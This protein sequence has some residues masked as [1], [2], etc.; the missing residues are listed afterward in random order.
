MML[1]EAMKVVLEKTPHK[2]ASIYYIQNQITQRNLYK[3]KD[4][5]PPKLFQ[6]KLRPYHHNDMLEFIKPDII[7]LKQFI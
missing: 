2:M 7:K 4:G 1:H 6:L 3:R 5:G